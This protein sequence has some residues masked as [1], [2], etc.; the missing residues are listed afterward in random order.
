M[1]PLRVPI[2]QKERPRTI[3][4]SKSATASGERTGYWSTVEKPGRL[5]Q[6]DVA[7]CHVGRLT[8]RSMSWPALVRSGGSVM[9]SGR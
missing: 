5:R 9:G 4:A 8:E 7:G 2:S 6:I 3:G 1:S